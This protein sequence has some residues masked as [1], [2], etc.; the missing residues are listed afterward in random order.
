MSESSR[1]AVL[2]CVINIWITVT[3]GCGSYFECLMLNFQSD[4][5]V[6]TISRCQERIQRSCN[7][8]VKLPIWNY[9]LCFNYINI[10]T[11]SSSPLSWCSLGKVT[12]KLWIL[13]THTILL[14]FFHLLPSSGRNKLR[15]VNEI[16]DR[17]WDS[18]CLGFNYLIPIHYVTIIHQRARR[19][20]EFHAE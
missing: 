5:M 15:E 2:R 18:S 9:I 1:K 19:K 20:L 14:N 6:P 16:T 17:T 11:I 7:H 13:S 8:Q 12:V 3:V 10:L 4:G